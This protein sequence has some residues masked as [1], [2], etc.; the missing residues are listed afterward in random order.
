MPRSITTF[1]QAHIAV[2]VLTAAAHFAAPPAS[3]TGGDAGATAKPVAEQ[4]LPNLPGTRLIAL[5]VT[6]AP[7]AKSARHH[8]AGSVWVYVLSGTIRSQNSA[9]GPARSTGRA[10]ASSS[11]RAAS[12]SENASASEP[13]SL[14]AVHI[15]DDGAPLTT[16]DK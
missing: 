11:R 3:A 4:D 13:A 9:T 6:Y 2:A 14:L 10:R 5:A 15:A 7:G 16:I 1:R 12:V 8:H